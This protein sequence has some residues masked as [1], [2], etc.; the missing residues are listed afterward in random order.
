MMY[1]RYKNVRN[2]KLEASGER[3]EENQVQV[4]LRK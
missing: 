4:G 3:V 2:E 1:R